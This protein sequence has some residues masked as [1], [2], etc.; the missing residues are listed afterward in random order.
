MGIGDKVM[1]KMGK[2]AVKELKGNMQDIITES[3]ET[4]RLL[5][6]ILDELKE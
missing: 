3:K 6:E 5:E 4:N 2:E 1:E